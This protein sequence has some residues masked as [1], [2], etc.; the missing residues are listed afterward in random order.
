MGYA[1]VMKKM[2]I[3]VMACLV[4]GIGGALLYLYYRPSAVVARV[5]AKLKSG[6]PNPKASLVAKSLTNGGHT[7]HLQFFSDALVDH[8]GPLAQSVSQT[9]V[10]VRPGHVDTSYIVMASPIDNNNTALRSDCGSRDPAAV[11]FTVKLDGQTV[12]I[13][14][15]TK[16][17]YNIYAMD[18]RSTGTWEQI[19]IF[20]N[21]LVSLQPHD[22]VL[23]TIF[24]SIRIQ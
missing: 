10:L 24:S 19:I 6:Q 9:E 12:S 20:N 18:V 8:G 11:E 4:V 23:K 15:G 3:W 2:I 14:H 5:E 16:E 17:P 1:G 13:C 21:A 22:D 7:Y